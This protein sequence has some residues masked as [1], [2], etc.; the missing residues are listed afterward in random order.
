MKYIDLQ[1][2]RDFW[3]RQSNWAA[4]DARVDEFKEE[5]LLSP[6][7]GWMEYHGHGAIWIDEDVTT[8]VW[9]DFDRDDLEHAGMLK[10][11]LTEEQI[12][13]GTKTIPNPLNCV[14]TIEAEK[15]AEPQLSRLVFYWRS[16][17]K[18]AAWILW[19]AACAYNLAILWIKYF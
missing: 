18:K 13:I 1:L 17:W 11:L 10:Y 12:W 5:A 15:E 2:E 14:V 16:N 9:W 6:N 3:G 19:W 4:A 7:K 8:F